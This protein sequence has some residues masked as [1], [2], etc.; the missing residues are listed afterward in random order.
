MMDIKIKLLEPLE[1]W[2]IKLKHNPIFLSLKFKFLFWN[3]LVS[4]LTMVIILIVFFETTSYALYSQFDSNIIYNAHEVA[5][6]VNHS[7]GLSS[8]KIVRF[9]DKNLIGYFVVILNSNG[10]IV[11]ESNKYNLNSK[12][13]QQVFSAVEKKSISSV[14][15]QQIGGSEVRMVSLPVFTNGQLDGVVI[16][17]N[18]FDVIKEALNRLFDV[19]IMVALI[20]ILLIF[21]ITYYLSEKVTQPLYEITSQIVAITG[22][23]L[24]QRLETEGYELEFKAMAE[25]FNKL[26]DRLEDTFERERIFINDVAHEIKTPLAI[27]N[28]ETELALRKKQSLEQYEKI[29]KA[30]L[31]ENTRI[32]KVINDVLSLA[33]LEY[34]TSMSKN[35][36]FDLLDVTNAIAED[37]RILSDAKKLN[38]E[39]KV[40]GKNFHMFGSKE[41]TRKALYNICTNALKYTKKGS[42][43]IILYKKLKRIYIIVEDTGVGIES[44]DIDKIFDRFYRGKNTKSFDG[45]GLGLSLAKSIIEKNK[46]T[47]LVESTVLKGTKFEI[48]FPEFK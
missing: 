1:A 8:S 48:S 27:M 9:Y 16:V 13:I 4:L 33:R 35:T 32:A 7:S 2:V 38:F 42:I 21:I 22:F 45:S 37:L 40:K 11:E 15:T 25:E 43:K 12:F 36:K 6:V 28:G 19:M 14:F 23:N 34:Q 41:T 3:L 10:N 46:G 24:K 39:Y 47:I 44:K 20:F 26:F 29:L 31:Y 5:N 17:G 30:N 18:S